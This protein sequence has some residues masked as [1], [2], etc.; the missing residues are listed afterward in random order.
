MTTS[1]AYTAIGKPIGQIEGPAKV[2]GKGAYTADVALPGVLWGKALRSPF[3]HARIVS[4]DT[5]RARALMGVHGVITGRD[6]PDVLYGRRMRDMPLLAR[7][8]VRFVGEKVAAVAAETPEIAAEALR[9]IEVEYQELPA[10]F[11]PQE[12]MGPGAPRLHDDVSAYPGHREPVSDLTNVFSVVRRTKG[13]LEQGFRESDLV[14]EHTF[15]TPAQHQGYLEPHA[16]LVDIQQGRIHVWVS[17][18]SPYA[19]REQLAQVLGVPEEQIVVHLPHVGG[20][21]GGKGA[22]MDAPLCYYLAR[23]SGRPVKMVMTYLEELMAGNPR[24]TGVITFKTG[25][26]RDGRL[27]AWQARCVWNTGAYGAFL[28]IPTVNV[29]GGM[30]SAG[31][32][33]IPHVEIESLCIYTNCV[34]RGHMRS[35]G[36]PQVCFA[37]ESHVDMMARALGMD[38]LAFRL[39]NVLEEGDTTPTGEALRDVHAKE[40]LQAAAAASGWDTP[41]QRP[42]HGRGMALYDRHVGSG[43]STV[44]LTMAEDGRA[45]LTTVAP[46]TGTGSHTILQ[47]IVAEELHL[48]LSQVGVTVGTTDA[49]PFDAGV[50]GSRT[51]HITGQAA[52]RAS[53]ELKGL[54]AAAAAQVLGVAADA[55]R[56]EQGSFVA[57]GSGAARSLPVAEA[58]RL[59]TRAAGGP[60]RVQITHDGGSTA[61]I[62]SF[63]VQVADV[64]VDPETGQVTVERI[65]SAHDV[66]TIIN[67]LGHQGQIEGG[68]IQSLGFA[69]SEELVIEEGRVTTLHLGEYK[70]PVMKDIPELVTVLVQHPEGPV[71][72]AGKAIGEVSNCPVA[73]AIANAVEDAVGVRI[74]DLPITA[75]KVYRALRAKP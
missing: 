53:Q 45:T 71:P 27:W 72:Y 70:L 61:G 3:P 42:H 2:S 31:S 34:P 26:K 59:A 20:D 11:D 52:Y 6:L 28:P 58:A 40:T 54:L 47:Q 50:G 36:A 48:P 33:R 64:Q 23:A 51:T 57:T 16:A 75:E 14:F 39:M 65:V 69:T 4:V 17:N 44:T 38:P 66:G 43:L 7:D 1:P 24:N 15:T 25:V 22:L 5:S 37:V 10:V 62:T 9:L 18:K 49:A 30:Q 41:K 60:L 12:A 55:L 13:D 68:I 8:R 21:F 35:P 73:A 46:D 56:L 67:P 63:C 29:A 19:V 74:T 32:Y